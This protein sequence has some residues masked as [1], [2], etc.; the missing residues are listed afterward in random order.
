[1]NAGEK[2]IMWAALW[3]EGNT[4]RADANCDEKDLRK[5]LRRLSDKSP[6]RKM[7]V[8]VNISRIVDTPGRSTITF[9]RTFR[10]VVTRR[11]S[12]HYET[13]APHT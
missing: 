13:P 9:E 8:M 5:T 7:R 2:V 1:M 12:L 10:V 11:V 4:T 3:V 6:T